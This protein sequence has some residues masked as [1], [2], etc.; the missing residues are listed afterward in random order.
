MHFL[1][2]QGYEG[3]YEVSDTGLVRSLDELGREHELNESL[4]IQ[5]ITRAR[6]NGAKNFNTNLI[7]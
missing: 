7:N 4:K 5:R 2:V 3:L 6:I 1:P